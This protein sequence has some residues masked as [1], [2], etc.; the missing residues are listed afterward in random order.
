MVSAAMSLLGSACSQQSANSEPGRVLG[1]ARALG[2]GNVTSYA[3]FDRS[4][5]PTTIGV[6]LSAGALDGLPRTH[7]DG[8]RCFDSDGNG[9]ID[10][11]R[12]CS[13]WHEF[14]LPLPSDA[15]RRADIPFKWALFNWNP[16][17]HIPADVWDSPH[18]DVHFYIE[19]IENVFA[20]QRGPCGVEFVRCD[21]YER[22]IK[23]LPSNYIHPDF[24]DVGVVAPAM[25]NHLID[26]SAP[27]F[28]GEP[29]KRHWIFGTYDGRIIF[30]EEMVS[31]D[32]LV[33]Q[34][35]ACFDIKTPPAVELSGYYP[36]RSCV[37]YSEDRDEYTVSMEGFVNRRASQPAAQ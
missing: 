1:P 19:P 33:S 27:E 8:N 36:T 16:Y 14:V 35:D 20:I 17:G 9:N 21:Q 37:R 30:Y 26:P 6:V 11:T 3:E 24:K 5:A 7:S 32:Y 18:F 28:S 31:R 15:S 2:D 13:Q 12:E 25:G 22:A 29:F 23:P 34:P 10:L 4:G